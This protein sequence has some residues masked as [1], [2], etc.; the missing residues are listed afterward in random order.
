L[1]VIVTVADG[2]ND[3][4]PNVYPVGAVGGVSEIVHCVPV[5]IPVI[6][7]DVVPAVTDFDPSCAEP[8]LQS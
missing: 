1:F 2:K 3:G 7:D 4:A 5:G 8:S 6:A